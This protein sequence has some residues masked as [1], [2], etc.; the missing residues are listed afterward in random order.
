MDR[1]ELKLQIPISYDETIH[2]VTALIFYDVTLQDKAR[3]KFEAVSYIDY[4]SIQPVSKVHIDGDITFKQTW[5]LVAKGGFRTPYSDEKLLE[6]RND[7]SESDS[8]ILTIMNKYNQRNFTMT[9]Q[10][11]Y[12]HKE[13]FV[14]S[15]E[16]S[17]PRTVDVSIVGRVVAGPV[18]VTPGVSEVLKWAWIQYVAIFVVIVTLLLRMSSFVFRHQLL[19]THV[20]PDMVVSKSY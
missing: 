3:Y 13:L 16:S 1:L 10:T 2:G 9:F 15:Y 7:L 20:I 19:Y 8:S 11:N 17:E 18:R 12:A 6:L 5:P 4:S 14:G